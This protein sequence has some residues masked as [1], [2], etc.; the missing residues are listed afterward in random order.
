MPSNGFKAS[1][2][3]NHNHGNQYH[4]NFR[5]DQQEQ[6]GLEPS[7]LD[8]TNLYIKGLWKDCTQVELDDL[9]KKFGVISQSRVYGDGVGFVRFEQAHEAKRAI[10]A[11]H[12]KKLDRCPDQ[13][14]VKYAFKKQR[15]DKRY[16]RVG[17]E[18]KQYPS[19]E[20][21]M[22][23]NKNTNNVYLRGFPRGY[24][25]QMLTALCE[26]YGELTCTRL[27]ESGVAFVRYRK[28]EDAQN[29]IRQ[30]N[31]K[32]FDNHN[33]T[34]LAKYANSDP[35]QPKIGF[36]QHRQFED[37]EDLSPQQ[38]HDGNQHMVDNNTPPNANGVNGGN[39]HQ[40][41]SYTQP[42]RRQHLHSQH[43]HH[44]VNQHHAMNGNQHQNMSPH[45]NHQYAPNPHGSAN[46][47]PNHG[48]R[49][50][51]N[52]HPIPNRN[53]NANNNG[54]NNQNGVNVQGQLYVANNPAQ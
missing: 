8:G 29:A 16:I 25:E 22:I 13:L 54:N 3:S 42:P 49:R 20:V 33:E 36:K 51:L 4:N 46:G 28:P 10:G 41:R 43:Q 26:P 24:T 12:G 53:I 45:R 40:E 9:F 18:V 14:L 27:R 2:S 37:E 23:M 5:F 50:N 15:R 47:T 7:D 17:D 39:Q 21:E 11:M 38:Q 52:N 32:R 19:L 31:G 44:A 48:Q 1:S 34:L 6:S 35:F 30:L